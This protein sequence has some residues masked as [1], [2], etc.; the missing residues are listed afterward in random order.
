MNGNSF[1]K[2]YI[3]LEDSFR[4]QAESDGDVFLPNIQPRGP[5]DVV[6]IAMEPSL[7]RWS[8]SVEDAQAKVA[9]GFR[10][11]LFS[12]EDFILHFSIKSFLCSE[13]QSYHLTDLSKGAMSVKRADQDRPERYDRWYGLLENELALVAKPSAGFFAIGKQVKDFLSMRSNRRFA[14]LLQ[15]APQASK[16]RKAFVLGREAEFE[17]FASRV[18]LADIERVAERV[19]SEAEMPPDMI[20]GTMARIRASTLTDSRKQLI[21][22]Y[23]IQMG[24]AL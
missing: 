10:N 2:Q 22:A 6:L 23:K 9:S 21:F 24:E 1:I 4:H 14:K 5:V 19:M 17:R 12:V 20:D 18:R 13:G 8:K 11:F 15:H 16:H 3:N 7:K